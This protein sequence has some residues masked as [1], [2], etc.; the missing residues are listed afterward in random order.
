MKLVQ[1]IEQQPA[2]CAPPV[3]SRIPGS[4]RVRLRSRDHEDPELNVISLVDVVLLLLIFF[5]L[6]TKFVDESRIELQLPQASKEPAAAQ[7]HDPIEVGVTASGEYRVNGQTLIN[8]SPATLSAAIAKVAG[9]ARDVPVTIRADAR[10]T[11]QSVVTAMDVLGRLGF[12]A[13]SI[14]TVNDSRAL[15]RGLTHAPA[16]M[17]APNAARSQA[18]ARRVADL[19]P[20][21]RLPAPA[22]R[23]VPARPARRRAVRGEHGELHGVREGVRRRHVREAR[24]AHD[25]LAAARA[26]RPVPAARPR[27]FHADLLHGLRR[28]PHRQAAARADLRAHG[29]AAHRL[30]RPQFEQ[31]AAVA[32]DVQH[33]AGRPGGDRLGH[34]HRA[35]I[36]DDVRL[37]RLRCSIVNYAARADLAHHGPA[38]RVAGD[39]HQPQVPPLQ[40][41]HPGLDGRHHARRQGNAGRAADGQGLQRAGVIRTRSSRPSTSTIAARTCAWCSPRACRI[42]WCRW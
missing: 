9:E 20:P 26:D 19:P 17:H 15:G 22:S 25:R 1:A 32:A 30:L 34:R 33:R 36:A 29:A 37:D 11:H 10:A 35:R 21:D 6:S 4:R 38:G 18:A 16:R 41:A 13:I 24:P 42:R 27:R 28:A 8:T 12:R 31:R 23:R 39:D 14:A 7:K 2:S 40:P 3:A 5:M